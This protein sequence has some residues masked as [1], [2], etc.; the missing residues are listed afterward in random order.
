MGEKR[1]RPVSLAGEEDSGQRFRRR[2]IRSSSNGRVGRAMVMLLGALAMLSPGMIAA[3]SARAQD[4]PVKNDAATKAE[5]PRAQVTEPPAQ[6]QASAEALSLHYRFIERYSATENPAHPELLTQYQVGLKETQ[7]TEREKQQGAPDRFQFTHRTVYTE[8]TAGAGKMGEL[9]S[10]VRRYDRFKVEDVATAQRPKVPFFEG[11][12]VMY[13]LQP[14]QRTVVVNLTDDRPLREIE[15]SRITTQVLVP[16]LTALLP[17][18]PRLVGDT[19]PIP[20]KAAETLV[21]EMPSAEDYDM[22]ASL[23]EVRKAGA[24]PALTAVI[25]ISGQMNLP[26]Y[27]ISSLNAQIHFVFNP[28]AAV[29]PSAGSAASSRSGDGPASKG[30][31]RPDAGIVDARGYISHVLMA[32]KATNLIPDE[33]ARLKQSRTYELELERRIASSANDAAGGPKAP[34]PVPQPIPSANEANSWL[35][36][37]DPM[38]RFYLLHPQDLALNAGMSDMNNIHLVDQDQGQGKDAFILKLNP[39]AQDPQAD[40]KFRD[41]GEFQRAIADHWTKLKLET[42]PGPAGWLPEA[43]WAPLKVYR[44]ELAVK[45]S[46]AEEG[47][48]GAQRIYIDDYL[49]LS[50]SNQ[51]FQVES[52][53]VRDDHVTFRTQ[54]EGIIKSFHFGKWDLQPKAPATAP[55]APPRTP[56]N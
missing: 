26:T 32:W 48:T 17:P 21:G 20:A 51:C 33:D 16:R 6:E 15:Y 22:T 5:A 30:G 14:G 18:T 2:L 24:G 41:V 45:T 52:W 56:A 38:E 43:D 55:A 4:T 7:K 42:L 11:L 23:V 31:R 39:G 49:V 53:T 12:T 46:N 28:V 40:R 13:K 36:Y 35:L 1:C 25:G 19:W 29:P 44:K 47:G 50:K 54:S 3:V 9:T 10:A 8:R 34:L 27:G 37:Q